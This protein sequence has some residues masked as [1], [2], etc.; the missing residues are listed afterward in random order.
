MVI[1]YVSMTLI[2]ENS[3]RVMDEGYEYHVWTVNESAIASRFSEWN[4]QSITTDVPSYI[5]KHL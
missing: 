2:H 5:R 4:V 1:S 3:Q